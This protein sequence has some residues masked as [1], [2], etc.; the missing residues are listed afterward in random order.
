MKERDIYSALKYYN[1]Y[2]AVKNGTILRRIARRLF[3]KV[4]G[5]LAR[6]LFG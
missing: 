3:G 2:K 4:A 5:R 1:D 6:R